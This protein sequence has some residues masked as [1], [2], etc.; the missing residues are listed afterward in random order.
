[1]FVLDNSVLID[2][3]TFCLTAPNRSNY[4]AGYCKGLSKVTDGGSDT[5]VVGSTTQVLFLV[6]D[7]E[8]LTWLGLP[9][10]ADT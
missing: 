2:L 3:F 8:I 7:S 1:M 4:C 6:N 9:S 5:V 10:T